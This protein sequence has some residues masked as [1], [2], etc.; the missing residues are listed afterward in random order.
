M[1]A[2]TPLRRRGP[3]GGTGH[4]I[5]IILVLGLQLDPVKRAIY[6]CLC[7]VGEI[8]DAVEHPLG[9]SPLSHDTS[10]TQ[11]REMLRNAWL[12]NLQRV[13]ELAHASPHT[14]VSA[15]ESSAPT[16]TQSADKA[17]F[18]NICAHCTYIGAAHEAQ[19]S[20]FGRPAETEQL[21][22]EPQE[23]RTNGPPSMTQLKVPGVAMRSAA[24]G[25]DRQPEHGFW[26]IRI[27]VPKSL[28]IGRSR[29]PLR[30]STSI[31]RV[32]SSAG[33]PQSQ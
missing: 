15:C 1:V 8:G 31:G 2:R 20:T 24:G 16:D 5:K 19:Q 17:A 7:P 3:V 11:D 9:V 29:V 27:C 10:L 30:S 12:G 18:G 25:P 28:A 22:Y 4:P 26:A 6:N 32:S 14:C 33:A 13:G 23:E 21:T